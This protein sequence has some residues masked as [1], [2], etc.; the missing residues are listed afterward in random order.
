M[1][2]VYFIIEYLSNNFYLLSDNRY[3][4]RRDIRYFTA[5]NTACQEV[6][7]IMHRIS[8]FLFSG[9]INITAYQALLRL[10]S[11]VH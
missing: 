2:Y 5:V 1:T 8:H 9:T 4:H 11:S 3:V 7:G 10:S 6:D